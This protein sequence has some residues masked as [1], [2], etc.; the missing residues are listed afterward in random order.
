MATIKLWGFSASTY[1]RTVRMVLF[2]KGV[3]DYEHD[4]VNVLEGETSQPAHLERHPL[5]K[6]PVVDVDGFRIIE[7]GAICQYLNTVLPGRSLIPTD[8]VMRA[9]MDM[10]FAVVGTYGYPAMVG[11]VAAYHLFPELVGGK[12]EDA[13][14][15]GLEKG[16]KVVEF[17]MATRAGDPWIA[18]ADVSIADYMLAPVMAYVSVT[19]DADALM[20][21]PGVADWWRAVSTLESFR[22]TD[23]L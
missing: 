12:N 19:P 9:R 18:G 17:A 8:P 14:Q 1:V 15:A 7:T 13:R 21:L 20:S 3:H 2:D 5:G 6:V 23:P 10:V 16:R 22:H 11:G 4:P